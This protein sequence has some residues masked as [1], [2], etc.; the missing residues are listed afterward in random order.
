MG[1]VSVDGMNPYDF[2]A[3]YGVGAFPVKDKSKEPMHSEL[4]QIEKNGE[5]RRSWE[6]LVDK[7]AEPDKRTEWGKAYHNHAVI[8]GSKLI[9]LDWENE[10]DIKIVFTGFDELVKET[11]VIK[12]GKGY[13]IYM[14]CDWEEDYAMIQKDGVTVCEVRT[15]AHYVV[16]AGSIHPNG[17]EY[18]KIGCDVPKETTKADFEK[19][20]AHVI[21]LGYNYKVKSK[22]GR[23]QPTVASGV[24]GAETNIDVALKHATHDT[25]F[26]KLLKGDVSDYTSRSE[27]EMGLVCKLIY[28]NASKEAIMDFMD[29]VNPVGKWTDA[30]RGYKELTYSKALDFQK[31]R[32]QDV[33]MYG[34]RMIMPKTVIR[35]ENGRIEIKEQYRYT[36]ENIILEKHIWR[37]REKPGEVD[38]PPADGKRKKKETYSVKIIEET[39]VLAGRLDVISRVEFE[40]LEDE[41]VNKWHIQFKGEDFVGDIDEI[42]EHLYFNANVLCTKDEM[43]RVIAHIITTS[44]NVGVTKVYP[45][46]GIYYNQHSGV[47]T[48]A[49]DANTVHPTTDSQEVFFKTF[50]GAMNGHCEMEQ[51]QAVA[52]ATV[53]F[54]DAMPKV[55][56]Y[57]AL[58]GRGYACIAPLAYVIK[59]SRVNVFPYLY[60]YGAKGSSKTQIATTAATF[61][62]GERE[63]LASDAVES[64]FR[65]GTEF[66]ATTLPRVI[67]EAHDVFIKNISIFK[68]G[69]TSTLATK[70]GNKDKTLD[71]YSAFCS[72]IFTSNMMPISA[73]ED[74]QGA[75]M[76]RVLVVECDS[77]PDFNKDKYQKAMGLLMRKSN[78]FGKHL[79]NYLGR[80]VQ[81]EG[82]VEIL[83]NE[84][85]RIADIFTSIDEKITIRRAYC[86]AEAAMGIKIYA[87]VLQDIGVPFPYGHLLV[88][89]RALCDMIYSKI[90]EEI[91]NE[92]HMNLINFLQ[93]A[94]SLATGDDRKASDAGLYQSPIRT[95]QIPGTKGNLFDNIQDTGIIVTTN[96]FAMYKKMQ[97]IQ[98]RPYTKLPELKKAMERIG[99]I[100]LEITSHRD[101][102]LGLHWGLRFS[103]EEY[104]DLI[105]KIMDK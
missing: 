73:E 74:L 23:A 102:N 84:L 4:P 31:E 59:E 18:T 48:M 50:T 54:I 90:Q 6:P 37:S 70:R 7:P 100:D 60:L 29:R 55:N 14:F 94:V 82:G 1:E 62:F 33:P 10:V 101:R 61:V 69:A 89:D 75:V 79:L 24:I 36:D 77:G 65:L 3:K 40:A 58:I 25:K 28:Y 47:V 35:D 22:P 15:G 105:G 96:A 32:Y 76:D 56:S 43:R 2:W 17:K 64:A 42:I 63:V 26:D 86:L 57:A 81:K 52:Q 66:T 104:E 99:C 45:A 51:L 53:D 67:D 20:K 41:K 39:V 92:E 98:S 38:M 83:V 19:F 78:V 13:H 80:L 68:S 21:K 46:I 16:G 87:D 72:F 88:D 8:S 27:A 9:V 5:T 85:L 97:G 91:K 11:Y 30:P 49:L 95:K 12:T 93:W 44:P 71:R 34:T 103:K